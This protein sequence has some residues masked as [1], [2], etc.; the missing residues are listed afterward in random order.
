[1]EIKDTIEKTSKLKMYWVLFY[2]FFKASTFT[3]AGGLAILPAIKHDLVEKYNLITEKDFMEYATLSQT[4]P[5][6]IVLNFASLVG[7]HTAGFLGMIIAGMG[8][9]FPA[10]FLMLVATILAEMIPKEGAVLGA[11]KGIR[12]ASAAMILSAV[13]SLGKYNIKNA[14]SLI[15]MISTFMLAVFLNVEAPLLVILSAL[16]GWLYNRMIRNKHKK[17]KPENKE[18]ESQ[19]GND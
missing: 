10:F 5:G 9:I 7:R 6:V 16:V 11:V 19:N 17:Q 4:F 3:F 8:A 1:L 12:A 13:F 14:F 15:I 2:T 18:E